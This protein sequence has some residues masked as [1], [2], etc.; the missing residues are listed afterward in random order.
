[1]K[2]TKTNAMRLLDQAKIDYQVH[3]YPHGK[4]AV[5]GVE[6]ACLMKED[7]ACVFKTLIT[8]ANTKE[9]LVFMV[10]VAKELDLKKAAKAAGVKN[11]EMIHVKDITKVSGYVRGGCSPLAMKKQYRTF[12]DESALLQDHIYFSG[13]K[14][15]LQIET[16]PNQLIELLQ[17]QATAVVKE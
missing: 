2:T 14:I 12:I 7:P 6:V 5:D 4:D 10:P 15:G 11:T 8:Q 16:D 13:G 3:E 9:Y 17:I 1:M